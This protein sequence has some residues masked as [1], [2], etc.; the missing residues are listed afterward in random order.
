MYTKTRSIEELL[1]CVHPA[2]SPTETYSIKGGST[3]EDAG[4]E[5]DRKE[6]RGQGREDVQNGSGP[7]HSEG[8]R[9]L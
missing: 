3:Y 1:N 2:L 4:F 8:G 7:R 5:G 6:E 9:E